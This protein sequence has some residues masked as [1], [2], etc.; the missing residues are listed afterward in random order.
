MSD[1]TSSPHTVNGS[2][3]ES[4]LYSTVNSFMI[5]YLCVFVTTF[6]VRE[7]ESTVQLGRYFMKGFCEIQHFFSN[8]VPVEEE[9]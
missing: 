3:R 6:Q 1:I 8:C 2:L 9:N 7:V 4:T 5:T